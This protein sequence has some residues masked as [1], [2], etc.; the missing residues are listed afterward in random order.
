MASKTEKEIMDALSTRG[1]YC[2]AS[3][4]AFKVAARLRDRNAIPGAYYSFNCWNAGTH[5]RYV[6]A[7]D[8]YISIPHKA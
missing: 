1:W 4:R 7:Q 6:P 5:G 3:R 2:S 8:V